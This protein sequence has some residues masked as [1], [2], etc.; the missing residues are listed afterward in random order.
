MEIKEIIQLIE[1][2]SENSLTSFELEQGN[3]RISIKKKGP[4]VMRV[5][6]T[7]GAAA[8]TAEEI[9]TVLDA[10][11]APAAEP[12]KADI[13]TLTAMAAASTPNRAAEN[14]TGLGWRI[15][16]TEDLASSA[17]TSRIRAATTSPERYS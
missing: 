4:K 5:A 17:P 2:V 10:P 6:G 3:T 13:H 11:A 15:F 8:G 14:S 1:A 7:A 12:K 16:S 9:V